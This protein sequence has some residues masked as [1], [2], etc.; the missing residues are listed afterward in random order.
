[1]RNTLKAIVT[2]AAAAAAGS[3]VAKLSLSVSAGVA[4]FAVIIVWRFG[5]ADPRFN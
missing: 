1:M 3:L 5:L 2:V 4:V